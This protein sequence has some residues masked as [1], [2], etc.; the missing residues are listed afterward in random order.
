MQLIELFMKNQR[1]TEVRFF[2][3]SG[4]F[5]MREQAAAFNRMLDSFVKA[6]G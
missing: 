4:H 2:N 1:K 3:R 6:N 5:V